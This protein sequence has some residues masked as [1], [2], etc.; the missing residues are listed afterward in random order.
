MNNGN[1]FDAPRLEA[2]LR[3]LFA[4]VRH[5]HVKNGNLRP[6]RLLADCCAL[7]EGAINW[8]GHL[9]LL[10]AL[11]QAAQPAA[12]TSSPRRARPAWVWA[13]LVVAAA[14]GGAL[15]ALALNFAASPYAMQE[16]LFWLLGS[17]ANRR[18]I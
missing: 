15:I 14:V 4:R 8:R 1:E 11:E 6:G 18:R 5:V 17:V 12:L 16:I 2:G 7:S 13:P 10:R 9:A 3:A